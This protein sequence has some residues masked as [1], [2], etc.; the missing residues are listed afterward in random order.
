MSPS[1]GQDQRTGRLRGAVLNLLG[2]N[3]QLIIH[4]DHPQTDHTQIRKNSKEN[5]YLWPPRTI[6]ISG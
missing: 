2:Y 6:P 1:H 3:G 5:T 4:P